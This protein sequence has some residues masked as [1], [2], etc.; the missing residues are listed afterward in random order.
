MQSTLE[1]PPWP[2]S[3][4]GGRLRTTMAAMWLSFTSS[5]T[6]KSLSTEQNAQAA[7]TF[8][9]KGKYL[10]AGKKLIDTGDASFRDVM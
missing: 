6:H 2:T 9:A 4:H 5:G 7:D 3:D 8:H 10:S 1:D